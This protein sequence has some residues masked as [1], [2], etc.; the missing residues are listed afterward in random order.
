MECGAVRTPCEIRQGDEA[1]GGQPGKASQD[2][3]Q[4]R[5]YDR[6][7]AARAPHS[8]QTARKITSL[9]HGARRDPQ[10]GIHNAPRVR[11]FW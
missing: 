2:K 10:W 7:H 1:L 3:G 4:R 6:R 11:V 5:A 9:P 8:A